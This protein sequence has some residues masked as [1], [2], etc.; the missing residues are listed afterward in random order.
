MLTT[1]T[2]NESHILATLLEVQCLT[3]DPISIN[4]NTLLE[5]NNSLVEIAKITPQIL[6]NLTKKGLI[7]TEGEFFYLP[8]TSLMMLTEIKTLKE[9]NKEI[10]EKLTLIQTQL[11]ILFDASPH[12]SKKFVV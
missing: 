11:D 4:I 5:Y 12:V 7:H 6:I 3:K 2:V 9:E 8:P 1:L 10:K